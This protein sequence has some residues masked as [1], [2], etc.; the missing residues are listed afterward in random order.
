MKLT[1][2]TIRLLSKKE[3]QPTRLKLALALGFSE[4]WIERVVD[5]NKDNGPLTTVMALQVIKAET[6]LEDSQ[7]L[8]MATIEEA[9][10]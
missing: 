2:H 1:K 10:K 7:V 3:H 4:R 6:G 8:E 5:Q 9:T